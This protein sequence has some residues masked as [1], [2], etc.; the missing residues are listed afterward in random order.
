MGI[1]F[2]R[3]GDRNWE[4]LHDIVNRNKQNEKGTFVIN[5]ID[6]KLSSCDQMLWKNQILLVQVDAL[7]DQNSYQ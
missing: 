1:W 3:I 5:D 4:L 7:L 6:I 2:C